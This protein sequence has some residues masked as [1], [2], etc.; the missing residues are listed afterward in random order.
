[1]SSVEYFDHDDEPYGLT[2]G[3]WTIKWCEWVMSIPDSL[4]PLTD[5]NGNHAAVNQPEKDV[6]FLAGTWTTKI[7]KHSKSEGNYSFWSINF[8][9]YNKL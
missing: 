7:I 9:S 6:W 8:I 4:S 3:Q 5:D 1:M 2:Y